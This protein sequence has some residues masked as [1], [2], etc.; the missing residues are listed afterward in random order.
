M[1]CAFGLEEAAVPPNDI[2]KPSKPPFKFASLLFV[3]TARQ[4]ESICSALASIATLIR[5]AYSDQS[6]R[7]GLF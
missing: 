2:D 7:V 3:A 6:E 4:N 1:E 5:E